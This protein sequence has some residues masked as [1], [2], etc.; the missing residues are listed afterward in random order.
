MPAICHNYF[1]FHFRMTK[2][3]FDV[4]DQKFVAFL[5]ATLGKMAGTQVIDPELINLDFW[6][7]WPRRF[8]NVRTYDS[9]KDDFEVPADPVDDFSASLEQEQDH[10]Q[11]QQRQQKQQQQQQ[12]QERQQE[13]ERPQQVQPQ[14]ERE[15]LQPDQEQQQ[16]QLEDQDE[17]DCQDEHQD[18]LQETCIPSRKV[19]QRKKKFNFLN[20]TFINPLQR[21]PK[22]SLPKTAKK[23]RPSS[24]M[25]AP[26]DSAVYFANMGLFN[27]YLDSCQIT[28]RMKRA[29]G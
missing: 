6:S 29:K 19:F 26:P 27:T 7:S 2:S 1:L 18:E 5:R 23:S 8:Y 24:E 13:Q 11:Q 10:H 4:V 14:V 3:N 17:H 25:P 12:Q 9:T 20:K 16:Q 15:L 22:K 21:G 28:S